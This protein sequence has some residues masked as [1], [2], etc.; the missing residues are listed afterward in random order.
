MS[1]ATKD[2]YLDVEVDTDVSVVEPCVGIVCACLPALR[3]MFHFLR[4]GRQ[5]SKSSGAKGDTTS[6][7]LL[8]SLWQKWSPTHSEDAKSCRSGHHHH[9]PT[10]NDDRVE[11]VKELSN[12]EMHSM[13]YC[14]LDTDRGMV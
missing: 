3:P 14:S 2:H 1:R 4:G 11:A 6:R 7:N 5:C 10:G 13:D 12:I 8:P 9:A